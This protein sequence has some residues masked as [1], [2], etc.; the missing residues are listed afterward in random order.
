M[1]WILIALVIAVC[2]HAMELVRLN[3]RLQH[4]RTELARAFNRVRHLRAEVRH[5]DTQF[6]ALWGKRA[7]ESVHVELRRVDV[8]SGPINNTRRE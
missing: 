7:P 6:D 5:L 8:P 1:I 4:T 3:R 2:F